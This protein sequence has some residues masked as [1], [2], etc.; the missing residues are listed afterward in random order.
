MTLPTTLELDEYGYPH[1]EWLASIRDARPAMADAAQWMRE[2]LPDLVS[3]VGYGRV[4]MDFF[5]QAEHSVYELRIATGGWSGMEDLMDAITGNWRL[6][7]FWEST[8]RGGLYV[9]R[10]PVRRVE[11]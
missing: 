2:T 3:K 11:G 4:T 6:M 1:D 5:P 8:H 9:F 7:Y 10:V